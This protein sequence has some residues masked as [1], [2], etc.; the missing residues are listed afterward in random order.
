[1]KKKL[2]MAVGVILAAGVGI[3]FVPVERDNPPVK[4]D[5]N[6]SPEVTRILRR[7]CYDCH[8]NETEWP[9]YGY[10]APVS[11]QLAQHVHQGRRY[12]NFSSWGTYA[13]D[14]RQALKAAV[15]M[16]V[17]QGRMPLK[18]YLLMHPDAELS[19]EEIARLQE[20]RQQQETGP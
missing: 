14:S 13:P 4:A 15:L 2:I 1:M 3:Q 11:W 10:I 7:S 16:T 18:P 8:S 6:A 17:Q 5:L 20:W 12:L 9:W 19:R